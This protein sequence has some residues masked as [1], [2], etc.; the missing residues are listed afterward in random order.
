VRDR[1]DTARVKVEPRVERLDAKRP[2]RLAQWGGWMAAAAAI[3]VLVLVLWPKPKPPPPTPA[4]ARAALLARGATPA[5]WTQ[6]E[7]PLSKGTSGDVV[8]DNDTQTGFMRFTGLAPNDPTKNQYQ[9]WIF[10]GTRPSEH[11]IDGGVFDVGPGGEV[12]VPIDAKIRV[13]EPTM[14]AVTLERPGGVVVSTRERLV[15][16]AKVPS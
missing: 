2:S 9:L 13:F 6:T 5:A 10:D 12:I 3:I 14:F 11:P 1:A 7:D 8:W 4:A 15:V 16:L